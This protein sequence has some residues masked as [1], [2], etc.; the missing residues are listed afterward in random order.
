MMWVSVL[1]KSSVLDRI[2]LWRWVYSVNIIIYCHL[3]VHSSK[4]SQV[5]VSSRCRLN[6]HSTL[7][8]ARILIKLEKTT[9]L[10]KWTIK[11]THYNLFHLQINSLLTCMLSRYFTLNWAG[12]RATGNIAANNSFL[13]L[14]CEIIMAEP[15]LCQSVSR[16]QRVS[17]SWWSLEL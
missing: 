12:T 8:W 2:N 1:M 13:L 14:R 15:L 4:V 17:Q 16:R 7:N 3:Q 11:E 6:R 9:L 10:R 5:K